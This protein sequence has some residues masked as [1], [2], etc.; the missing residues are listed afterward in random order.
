MNANMNKKLIAVIAT[1]PFIG[2]E[3]LYAHKTIVLI[4]LYLLLT[5]WVGKTHQCH[6]ESK[7]QV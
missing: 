5:I 6:L 2:S 7:N 1:T 3:S 4:S